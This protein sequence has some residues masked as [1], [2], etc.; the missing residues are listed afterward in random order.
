VKNDFL[1][2]LLEAKRQGRRVAAYGAAAKGNTLMNFA[3]VRPDLIGFVVD[4]N[5][6]KQGKLM[7]GSRVPIVAEERLR[8]EKPDYVVI[9]PWN[10]REE[11]TR[12]IGYV[13]DWGGRF[14]TAVPQL[15]IRP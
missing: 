12:Q 4:A 11:V 13:A 7:P 14:V 8:Q 6:A 15:E 5:P 3:G 10:L 2:F 1:E 9:L